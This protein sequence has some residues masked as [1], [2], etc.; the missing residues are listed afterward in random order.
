MLRMLMAQHQGNNAAKEEMM[1]IPQRSEQSS[2][3][4]TVPNSALIGSM[5]RRP[6]SY[7]R[8]IVAGMLVLTLAL[9]SI[10]AYYSLSGFFNANGM[11]YGTMAIQTGGRTLKI[12]TYM[13][14]STWPTGRIAGEGIFCIPLPLNNTATVEYRLSGKRTFPLPGN[15]QRDQQR[16]ITLTAQYG[17][18]LL[19]SLVLPLGP[20]LHLEGAA[21]PSRFHLVGGDGNAS[22]TLD[23]RHGTKSAFMAACESLAPLQGMLLPRRGG[24]G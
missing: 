19:L 5:P 24:T 6:P 14:V 21:S 13:D 15:S 3:P 2:E 9:G 16:P 23:V 20:S 22:T 11:W 10:A 1:A 17:I 18:P 8:R 7:L 4:P 12:E